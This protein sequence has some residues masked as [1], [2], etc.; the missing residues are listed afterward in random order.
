MPVVG[1]DAL[2]GGDPLV[3]PDVALDLTCLS[4]LEVRV[5][6]PLPRERE[7]RCKGVFPDCF[8]IS[9]AERLFA[10]GSRPPPDDA[11]AT[12]MAP[13]ASTSTPSRKRPD[14]SIAS[15]PTTITTTPRT[16]IAPLLR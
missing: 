8:P 14:S 1:I 3:G 15:T 7:A 4:L 5:G 9:I 2:A 16:F 11:T 13:T 10:A 6:A 12:R